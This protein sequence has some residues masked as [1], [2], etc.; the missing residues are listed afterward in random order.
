MI[1]V[2]RGISNLNDIQSAQC[3]SQSVALTGVIL[4]VPIVQYELDMS[5]REIICTKTWSYLKTV[6]IRLASGVIILSGGIT[7]FAW[8]MKHNNCIF[9]FGIFVF[10]T[11]LYAVFLGILG[12]IFS[13]IGRNV[14]VGYLAA[15]GYWSLCQLQILSENNVLF[16][17]PV[18]S[19]KFEIQKMII[20]IV[21]IVILINGIMVSIKK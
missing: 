5:I 12:I 2:I 8:V 6:S 7:G 15:F 18:V 16:L 1:P 17:F 21:V 3:F 10:S 14:I 20:L 13:Q 11:I 4:L 9:P 19:G